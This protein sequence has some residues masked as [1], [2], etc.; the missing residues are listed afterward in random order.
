MIEGEPG[1]VLFPGTA[2]RIVGPLRAQ[3]GDARA[4]EVLRVPEVGE[5][6]IMTAI[7]GLS[8]GAS[9]GPGHARG[10]VKTRLNPPRARVP[11]RSVV[12]MG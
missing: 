1:D 5:E 4:S 9:Q 2:A 10:L 12:M 6:A 8:K 7:K 3:V 11:E